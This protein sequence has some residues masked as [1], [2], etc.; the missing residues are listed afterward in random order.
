MPH[1]IGE[2]LLLLA[3]VVWLALLIFYVIQALRNPL[4]VRSEFRHPVQGSRPALLA[5]TTLLI[6]LAANP[7]SRSLA[8]I[9]TIVGIC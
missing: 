1:W 3:A 6:A 4:L 2:G 5:V 7:Y 9:L 8:Y